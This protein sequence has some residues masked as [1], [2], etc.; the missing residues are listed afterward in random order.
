MSRSTENGIVRQTDDLGRI[1]ISKELRTQL[2]LIHKSALEFYTDESR[3]IL[4]K[5]NP[6]CIICESMGDLSYYRN[7]RI[8]RECIDFIKA[9]R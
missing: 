8:C 4:K 5:Y 9:A 7:K 2:G 6:G 1:T 3:I